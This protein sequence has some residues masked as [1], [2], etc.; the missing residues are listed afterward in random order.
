MFDQDYYNT[1]N[2]NRAAGADEIKSAYRRMARKFHP[3]ISQEHDAEEKFKY[4]KQAYE[5]LSDPKKRADYDQ[6]LKNTHR[7]RSQPSS[8][9]DDQINSSFF[10]D[11]LKEEDRKHQANNGHLGDLFDNFFK[12]RK[13]TRSR[14]S[15]ESNAKS[16]KRRPFYKKKAPRIAD[17]ALDLEDVY[18]GATKMI[19]M[20]DGKNLQVKIPAGVTNG[21]KIR[22]N[23]KHKN[24]SELYLRVN[25]KPHPVFEV[26]GKDLALVLPISPWESALGSLISI[27]TLNGSVKLNIPEHSHSGKKFRLKGKG[28]PGQTNGDLYV[29]LSVIAPP[30]N[31]A[32]ERALYRQMESEFSWNPR[33]HLL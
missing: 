25:L 13:K 12:S 18:I 7:P 15:I 23:S 22:L 29:T 3:D 8:N 5:I 4:V 19:R 14:K 27:P 20:P 1:L 21:Q 24:G 2:V 10:E 9:N 11:L 26:D 32:K 6:E 17:I 30:A 16:S 31:T 33:S 28:L